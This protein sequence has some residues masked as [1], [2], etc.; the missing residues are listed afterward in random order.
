MEEKRVAEDCLL[1]GKKNDRIFGVEEM[2]RG[3][4]GV[5][6]RGGLEMRRLSLISQ[7]VSFK[8]NGR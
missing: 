2:N 6:K 8:E 3:F 1:F 7:R 5:V 4:E